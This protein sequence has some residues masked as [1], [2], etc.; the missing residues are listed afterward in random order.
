[1]FKRLKPVNVILFGKKV[2]TDVIKDF[3]IYSWTFRVG[4]KCHDRCL[5]QREE[6]RMEEGNRVMQLQ[7]EEHPARIAAGEAGRVLP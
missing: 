3:E 2:F 5:Y 4:C 7:A 1:M 6:E